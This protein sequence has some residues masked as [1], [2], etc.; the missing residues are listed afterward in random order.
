MRSNAYNVSQRERDEVMMYPSPLVTAKAMSRPYTKP[1]EESRVNSTYTKHYF[2]GTERINSTLGTTKTLG[3]YPSRIGAI[4]PN[5]RNHANISVQKANTGLTNTYEDLGLYINPNPPV[6]EDN[7]VDDFIHNVK[8]FDAYWYHSDHLGSSSYISNTKGVV[9]Q[10]MEYL[11]FGE[12]LVEEHQNSYNTPYKFNGKAMDDETGYYY[13]GARYYNPKLSVWLSVDPK[14]HLR[15]W[16]SPYNFAQNNPLNRIDPDGALDMEVQRPDDWVEKADGTI[17]WDDNAT[18]QETTK[19]GETY[20]GKNVLVGTHNRDATG[21]EAINTAQFDL[22]LESDKTGPTATIM[23]N[24][25]PSDITKSG[26]LAEGLY[27]ARFQGRASYLRKGKDDLAVIINEGK[28]VPTVNGNPNKANSDMLS[29][30]F[31]HAGN[32]ANP[33]LFTRSKSP[34]SAGCQTTGCGAGT[35]PLHNSFM[36]KV[37]RDFNGFYYL[38][39][40]PVL[41][42]P[43][44]VPFSSDLPGKQ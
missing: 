19:S 1:T 25:V 8:K 41:T 4:F 6:I 3:L 29:G 14:A 11:P 26:T 23:G 33:S 9:T 34:I 32:Y 17:Y 7:M 30:V 42:V 43:T 35:R 36:Q 2:I 44:I 31:L 24:T 38:R 10:H 5:L 40:K 13:Y 22:Y 21:N 20:L 12:T 39:A 15:S 16:V 37:G 27:P 18:S 28:D